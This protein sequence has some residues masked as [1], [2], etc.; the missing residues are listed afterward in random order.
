MSAEC[1]D[2]INRIF[3]VKAKERITIPEIQVRPSIGLGLWGCSWAAVQSGV[4]E[5]GSQASLLACAG[6]WVTA[7]MLV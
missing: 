7:E 6:R 5:A 1:K 2:L 3:V 4:V